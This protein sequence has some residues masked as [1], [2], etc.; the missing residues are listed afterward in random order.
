MEELELDR[1]NANSPY[2]VELDFSTGLF[3]FV[4]DFGVS[5]SVAF[6]KDELLQS[7]ESYQFALTNY[8]GTKS[9]RDSTNCDNLQP[10]AA[11]GERRQ[12]HEVLPM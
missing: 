9:P 2:I 12:K 4:S 5:F 10:D 7:G 3:K 1:I 8:E 6:E 11:G